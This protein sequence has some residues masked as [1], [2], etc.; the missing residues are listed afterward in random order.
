MT[1]KL[2]LLVIFIGV[3]LPLL[4]LVVWS[5]AHRWYFP[6]VLPTEWSGRAWGLWWGRG[7]RC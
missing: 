2:A 1:R 5:W 7:R 4:P 3:L 6:A